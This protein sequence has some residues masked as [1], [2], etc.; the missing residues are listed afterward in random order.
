MG[1]IVAAAALANQQQQQQQAQTQVVQQQLQQQQ[2][3]PQSLAQQQQQPQGLTQ[4]PASFNGSIAG[5]Q[6]AALTQGLNTVANT[7]ASVANSLGGL[8]TVQGLGTGEWI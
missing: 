1:A 8:G 6:Q 2:Q 7:Q 5:G 4:Q 3:Q